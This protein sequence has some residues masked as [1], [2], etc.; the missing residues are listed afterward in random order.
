MVCVLLHVAGE[1]YARDR[2]THGV[3]AAASGGRQAVHVLLWGAGKN[4]MRVLL[5]VAGEHMI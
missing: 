1:R 4:M 5:H 3:R 2:Q